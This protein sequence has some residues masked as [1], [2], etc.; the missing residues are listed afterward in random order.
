V[1]PTYA[2]LGKWIEKLVGNKSLSGTHTKVLVALW[3]ETGKRLSRIQ[4][5]GLIPIYEP[6]L[7]E[8]AGVS[9][10]T[11]SRSLMLLA[12]SNIVN[13]RV[14][15][16]EERRHLYLALSKQAIDHPEML[17]LKEA[18]NHGGL[19][20]KHCGGELVVTELTCSGCGQVYRKRGKK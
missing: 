9:V 5:D 15:Y 18:R 13:R 2:D 4:P 19:R 14:E 7:A 3:L 6:T 10:N 20:C 8:V 12:K 11:C 17:T 16:K 1:R